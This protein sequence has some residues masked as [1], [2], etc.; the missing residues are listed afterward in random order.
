MIAG[1]FVAALLLSQGELAPQDALQFNA[2][3]GTSW[4]ATFKQS[5]YAPRSAQQEIAFE[6]TGSHRI[7]R[8]A[9]GQLQVEGGW[10]M[11]QMWMDDE[12]LPGVKGEP[13]PYRW[14]L[15][16]NGFPKLVMDELGDSR[17]FRLARIVAFACPMKPSPYWLEEHPASDVGQVPRAQHTWKPLGTETWNGRKALRIEFE[18]KELERQH[19]LVAT[20]K[21][22]ADWSTGLLVELHAEGT[23]AQLP[24]GENEQYDFRVEYRVDPSTAVKWPR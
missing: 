7:V 6:F 18:F 24:G 1:W 4:K 17:A 8:S 19:P 14:D 13:I 10:L 9:D 22:L 2:Q 15:A 16:S 5:F 23:N 21:L 12:K 3:P 20:G 11:S